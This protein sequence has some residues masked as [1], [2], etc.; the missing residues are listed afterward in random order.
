M[1][2]GSGYALRGSTD[3]RA[4]AQSPGREGRAIQAQSDQ[5]NVEHGHEILLITEYQKDIQAKL[6]ATTPEHQPDLVVVWPEDLEAYLR[7]DT[8][9]PDAGWASEIERVRIC[10]RWRR[11]STPSMAGS[12]RCRWA[13]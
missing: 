13:W 9:H 1:R 6:A 5:F 3:H 10:C 11:H 7:D 12:R 2:A 4:V 8:S